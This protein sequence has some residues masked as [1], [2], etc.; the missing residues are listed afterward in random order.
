MS[1][2]SVWDEET[3]TRVR[4]DLCKGDDWYLHHESGISLIDLVREL[5]DENE[6][7]K[8]RAEKDLSEAKSRID[9]LEKSIIDSCH[10]ADLADSDC[11]SYHRDAITELYKQW[12]EILK[13]RYKDKSQKE[14][15]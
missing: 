14:G 4:A 6:R 12:G 3:L 7:Q 10:L 5:K 15:M 9:K 13:D 2:T 11:C 1:D 8:A